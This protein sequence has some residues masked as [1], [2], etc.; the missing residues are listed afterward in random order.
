MTTRVVFFTFAGRTANMEAQ[1]PYVEALLD[2]NPGSV[3]HLWDLTRNPVDQ[4]YVRE[5][6]ASDDRIAYMNQFHPGHPIRCIGPRRRGHPRCQCVIHKPPYEQPY[7]W[8]RDNAALYDADTVFVKFDDDVIWMGVE[9]FPEVLIFLNARPN[10]VA[11]ANVTN[12]AVCAKYEPRFRDDVMR[13]FGI[14]G[15]HPLHDRD[16]W[17]LHTSPAFAVLAHQWLNEYLL[18]P[19]NPRFGRPVRTRPGERVSINFIAMKFPTLCRV[20][21]MMCDGRLGDEGAVDSLLPWIIP[22]FRVAHLTFGPQEAPLGSRIN[23]LRASYAVHQPVE[24]QRKELA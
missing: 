22:N 4:V 3:L 1:R 11:S 16:W 6:A 14:V 5:W 24:T 7:R 18:S 13:H 10:A 2:Q 9:H 20:A 12:N 15:T 8:Y 21:G 17:A 19:A 23:T